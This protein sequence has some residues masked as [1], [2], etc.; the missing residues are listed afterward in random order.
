MFGMVMIRQAFIDNREAHKKGQVDEE[1]IELLESQDLE[2]EPDPMEFGDFRFYG[3]ASNKD[4]LSV[5]FEFKKNPSDIL[6]SL[7]DGR[8]VSQLI[9][10]TKVY[11]VAYLICIGDMDEIDF[12]NG[13]LM[14]LQREQRRLYYDEKEDSAWPYN[15]LNSIL[16]RFESMGGH[17]RYVR[18]L[19]HLAA[20]LL[21]SFDYWNKEREDESLF[22]R[23]TFDDWEVLDN[24]LAEFYERMGI[25]IAKAVHLS[26]YFPNV[27][28][29]IMLCDTGAPGLTVLSNLAIS[30]TKT[31]KQRNM[32][33]GTA[34]KIR[35]FLVKVHVSN[36]DETKRIKIALS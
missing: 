32:G 26:E 15:H 10:M 28:E 35:D 20:F 21:S 29:L 14:Q 11:D 18:D 4:I 22:Q 13:K 12:S 8:L 6:S 27:S 17:I 34:V 16:T 9:G 23:R 3:K 30:D 33:K 1:L 7:G 19:D 2:I 5:G 24:P 36:V 31:G 25:G